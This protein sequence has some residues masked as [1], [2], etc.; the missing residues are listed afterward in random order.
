[1]LRLQAHGH[2][3]SHPTLPPIVLSPPL[4]LQAMHLFKVLAVVATATTTPELR[5]PP[6][7]F[8]P[9]FMQSLFPLL[10]ADDLFIPYPKALGHKETPPHPVPPPTGMCGGRGGKGSGGEVQESGLGT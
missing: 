1:M 5:L 9:P 7:F 3:P 10:L 2:L 8:A 4:T 6:M